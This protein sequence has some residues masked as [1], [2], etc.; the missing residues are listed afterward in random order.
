[1]IRGW[2]LG[3]SPSLAAP[4]GDAPAVERIVLADIQKESDLY[5]RLLVNRN[6]NWLPKIR[7]TL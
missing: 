1:M 6:K 4:P 7:S 2:S 3:M 5:Q